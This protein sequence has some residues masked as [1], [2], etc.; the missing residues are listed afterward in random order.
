MEI[1]VVHHR[2]AG[3]DPDMERVLDAFRCVVVPYVREFNFSEMNNLGAQAAKH[4]ALIFLNDDVVPLENGWISRILQHLQRDDIG[5]VGA[6]LLYPDESLQHA[7]IVIG[8]GEGCGHVGRHQFTSELWPWL[9]LT[10]DVSA[11]TGACLGIRKDVWTKLE[12]F[13]TRYPVNFND[14]DL[15][16]RARA[17]GWR[18]I[19]EGSAVLQHEECRTRSGGTQ[20]R[21]REA[22]YRRWDRL[23]GKPDPFYSPWL[24]EEEHI[25]LKSLPSDVSF[26]A[27]I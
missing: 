16:L 24:A 14:V 1:V 18:V 4:P 15:C 2:P 23:M 25:S 17:A 6:R 8:V 11:V 10:R 5:A 21:E 27:A 3:G 7:G 19:I 26:V 20:V 12:G 9:N 22:F 13:D